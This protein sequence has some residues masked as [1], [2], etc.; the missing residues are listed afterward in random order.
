MELADALSNSAG[1]PVRSVD[2]PSSGGWYDPDSAAFLAGPERASDG[3]TRMTPQRRLEISA[4][5]PAGLRALSL[6]VR[7]RREAPETR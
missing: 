4:E 2:A 3:W 6:L 5:L 1:E 7:V